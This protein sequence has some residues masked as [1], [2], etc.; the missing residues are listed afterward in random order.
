MLPFAHGVIAER[1]GED[2]VF[3]Y[4]RETYPCEGLIARSAALGRALFPTKVVPCPTK[5]L[6]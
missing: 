2:S 3:S 4:N 1:L 6:W 5:L